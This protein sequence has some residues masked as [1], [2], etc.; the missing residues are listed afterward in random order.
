MLIVALITSLLFAGAPPANAD[1]YGHVAFA[2]SGAAAAQADFLEGLALLH[3]F[4]YPAAAVAFRRA[5]AADPGFA[6]A[7]WGE[8]MTFNHPIW[9][10][11]DL[12]SARAALNKLAPNAAARRAKAKTEREKAYLETIEIL[13]GEGSKIERDYNYEN[14]MAKLHESYPDDV[15]ASA[16][17]G[18][19]ILGTAHA[20]RDIPTYMRAARV[21]SYGDATGVKIGQAPRPEPGRGKVLVRV[22][23]AGVNALRARLGGGLDRSS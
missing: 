20:G 12:V 8:A 15:D 1:G 18:L 13:Y 4:E 16:F 22:K 9:M 3:D 5:E 21:H 7:Y 14:A 19:A 17:Y 2:N 23:A 10:Q 11:Q 6:M